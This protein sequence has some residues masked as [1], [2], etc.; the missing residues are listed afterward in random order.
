LSTREAASAVVVSPTLVY[1]IFNDDLNLKTFKF[2]LWHKLE[3]QNIEKKAKLTQPKTALKHP[4]LK[5]PDSTQA[6]SSMQR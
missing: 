3:D 6:I 4:H 2:H 1:Y 5:Q